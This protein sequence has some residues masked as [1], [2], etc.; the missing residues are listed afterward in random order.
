MLWPHLSGFQDPENLELYSCNEQ[1]FWKMDDLDHEFLSS[2][3]PMHIRII[4]CGVLSC[5]LVL[6]WV[7][8]S[9]QSTGQCQVC[10]E[11]T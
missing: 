9:F 11:A 4:M 1:D 2:K 6:L 5:L 3:I 8:K 10:S 7:Q